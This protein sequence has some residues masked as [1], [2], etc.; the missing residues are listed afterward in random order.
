MGKPFHKRFAQ[1]A[2]QLVQRVILDEALDHD[3][4]G[5]GS[6]AAK[7]DGKG[8]LPMQEIAG[9]GAVGG[10]WRISKR[11]FTVPEMKE[12]TVMCNSSGR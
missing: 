8:P 6:D 3:G 1:I 5:R 12:M 2:A 10:N 9:N 4:G 7:L 11:Q